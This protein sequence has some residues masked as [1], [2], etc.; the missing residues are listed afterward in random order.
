VGS[1]LGVS[2][3]QPSSG[4]VPADLIGTVK[5]AALTDTVDCAI[6]EVSAGIATT[7]DEINGL[8]LRG[9]NHLHAVTNGVSGMRVYKVGKKTGL[10]MGKIVDGDAAAK[11][12]YPSGTK[13]LTSLIKIVCQKVS[14]CCCCSCEV[15]DASHAFSDHGDS[16]AVVVSEH[17]M[18]VGLIVGGQP[19]ETYA[20]QMTRVEDALNVLVNREVSVLPP[21]SPPVVSP[22]S[23]ATPMGP[24][25]TPEDETLWSSLQRRLDESPF[26]REIGL[27]V[28]HHLPEAIDLVNHR[29]AVMVTWQRVQGPAF[30]AQWMNGIRNP[31]Q[32]MP[33]EI[34]G[35]TMNAALLRL[36]A[37]FKTHGSPALQ[38]AIDHYGLDLMALLDR[39]ST[40]DELID[41]LDSPVTA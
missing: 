18:A 9:S 22:L 16:G 6:I 36:A 4:G 24:S 19:S 13:T 17:R 1:T 23:G 8:F 27:Q 32:P 28:R 39:S 15:G 38:Q 11:F 20:C 34:E 14:G 35:V 41:N 7:I 25:P 3:F 2:V 31:S 12:S 29:R 5:R 10:T 21:V 30:L 40:V 26:G 37:V 33:H